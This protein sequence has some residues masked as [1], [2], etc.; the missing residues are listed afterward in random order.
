MFSEPFLQWLETY[1][2]QGS[3]YAMPEGSIIYPDEP[4]L[5]VYAPLID[6]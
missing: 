2:F 1:Q 6:A 3:V 4:L 5:T